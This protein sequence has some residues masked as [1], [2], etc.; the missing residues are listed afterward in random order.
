MAY[1]RPHKNVNSFVTEDPPYLVRDIR[2]L[3]ACELRSI[4][5]DRNPATKAAKC[6]CQFKADIAAAKHDQM[7]RHIAEL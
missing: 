6:L 3:S 4:L 2:I 5:D 1:L 7:V